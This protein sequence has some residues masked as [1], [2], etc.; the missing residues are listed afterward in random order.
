MNRSTHANAEMLLQVSELRS[1]LE[2]M[3]SDQ[4]NLQRKLQEQEDKQVCNTPVLWC[5]H[6]HLDLSK[7]SFDSLRLQRQARQQL[8][9]QVAQKKQIAE[10]EK[11]RVKE[12]EEENRSQKK[13]LEEK[14]DKLHSAHRYRMKGS[15][16]QDHH[17]ND[18]MTSNAAH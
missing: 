16:L 7:F 2:R 17:F 1:E 5:T 18:S 15:T 14:K 8:K 4:Q 13:D 12:L 10:N 3:R 6:W 9:D 11:R